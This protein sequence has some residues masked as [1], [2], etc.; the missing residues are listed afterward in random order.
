M[1]KKRHFIFTNHNHLKNHLLSSLDQPQ[2]QESSTLFAGSTSSSRIIYSRITQ[3]Q[4]QPSS[5][6]GAPV[7]AS[8]PRKWTYE[9]LITTVLTCNEQTIYWL[10]SKHLLASSMDCSKCSSQCRLV[11]RKSTLYWRCP[12]KGCQAVISVRDKSFFANSKLSLQTILKLMYQWTRQTRVTSAASEV[13]VSESV[14]IDWYNFFR[15]VCSQY[16]SST[17]PSLL[18]APEKQ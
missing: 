8:T 6:A 3:D 16:S 1:Y 13:K 4:S 2:L 11:K 14:A 17:T 7:L 18:G 12:R 15:D 5:M 9:E 10:Q